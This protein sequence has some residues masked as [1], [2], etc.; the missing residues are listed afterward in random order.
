MALRFVPMPTAEAT[1][2]Q[3]SAPD[4]NGQ[5]PEMHVAVKAAVPAATASSRSRPASAT[6]SSATGPFPEP[7]PYAEVGPI[8]LHA[9]ACGGYRAAELPP[10]LRTDGACIIRGYGGDDRIVYGS[11]RV[12]ANAKIPRGG[13]RALRRPAHRLYPR[14]L[15]DQ[16]LL[17]VPDRARLIACAQ[18][19]PMIAPITTATAS[20]C[21]ASIR[22]SAGLR[23]A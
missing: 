7:Q 1:A 13:G 16:Q 9:E 20:Q 12:V 21:P 10:I 8:F 17:P 22:V 19:A 3:A 4:A 23:A 14:P 18:K 11:G 2:L 6:S 15:G 5:S